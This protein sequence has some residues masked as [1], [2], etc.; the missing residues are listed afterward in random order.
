MKYRKSNRM[1]DRDY[2]KPGAYYVTLCTRNRE[3]MLCDI[4]NGQSVLSHYGE[5]VE[6][7]WKDLEN[8]FVNIELDAFVIMPNHL[9]AIV[10]L[11][12]AALAAAQTGG[13]S[14]GAGSQSV[15]PTPGAV[16]AVWAGARPARLD[17]AQF[18]GW[19]SRCHGRRR[20]GTGPSAR[21][22]GRRPVPGTSS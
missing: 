3:N 18:R 20:D 11:V 13:T 8:R 15:E 6:E 2:S 22:A 10:H 7:E 4:I 17:E 19:F 5:I 12:G 14:A 21:P 9:H 1:P 16:P